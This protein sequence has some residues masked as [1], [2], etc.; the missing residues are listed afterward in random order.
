MILYNKEGIPDVKSKVYSKFPSLR[1]NAKKA[2]KES[3]NVDKE[4]MIM[5]GGETRGGCL[6]C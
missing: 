6:N 3:E 5:M 1:K 4:I 2:K